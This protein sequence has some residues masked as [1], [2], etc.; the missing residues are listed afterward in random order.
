MVLQGVVTEYERYLI[1][2]F[3]DEAIEVFT[4][5]Y[6]RDCLN[7][8]YK[9]LN[10]IND[11]FQFSFYKLEV[12]FLND[13]FVYK[14][15][16]KHQSDLSLHHSKDKGIS[17]VSVYHPNYQK[18]FENRV[19]IEKL[20]HDAIQMKAFELNF[21]PIYHLDTKTVRAIEILIRW[22]DKTIKVSAGEWIA[23]AEETEQI[24][25]VDQWVINAAFEFVQNNLKDKDVITTINISSKTLLSDTFIEFVR[26][27]KAEFDIQPN[28]IE[29]ELTEHSLIDDLNNS[30]KQINDLKAL[31]FKIALD[32]FGTRY[33][34][35]NYLSHMPFD[36]LK[37]DK[38]YVDK[39]FN[40]PRDL[41]IVKQIVHLC[42]QLN[43][44][45]I[46]E[47][48]ESTEQ[49]ELLRKIKCDFGQGY[50]FS[51]PVDEKAILKLLEV[52]TGA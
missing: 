9:F 20:I 32:D 35:L 30:L 48:I 10:K 50:L 39:I 23:I 46:A 21:Q 45:T 52:T 37:I 11:Q 15:K 5:F 17:N 1:E 18:D 22:K 28:T 47:G 43:I 41:I 26:K 19:E 44:V 25:K 3:G 51:K 40:Q 33:S 27:A 24:L 38:S 16:I 31:G 29:F 8:E 7:T 12:D 4:S 49:L 2:N 13:I 42:T 34:S 36:S 14:M 6:Q